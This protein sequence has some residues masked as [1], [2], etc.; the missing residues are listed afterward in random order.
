M[1]F[2]IEYGP[3]EMVV[4]SHEPH[5]TI[6]DGIASVYLDSLEAQMLFEH[7]WASGIRP[8]GWPESNAVVMIN[9]LPAAD[10][11]STDPVP[12][13]YYTI[14]SFLARFD[15]E[16]I[17]LMGPLGEAT[18]R[19]GFWL[20]HQCK[21]EGIKPQKVLAPKVLHPYGI[22]RVNIYPEAMLRRRFG[23]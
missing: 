19:D 21:R 18:Q 15:P 16:T 10:Y 22:D 20:A 17:A 7:M 13:G 11:M 14:I 9:G 23:L 4:L 8:A 12:D 2:R 6:A 1:K 3:K 5:F